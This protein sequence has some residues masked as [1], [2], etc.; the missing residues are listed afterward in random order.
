MGVD[1]SLDDV[2]RDKEFVLCRYKHVEVF[3]NLASAHLPDSTRISVF[4]IQV[5]AYDSKDDW[6]VDETTLPRAGDL[7]DEFDLLAKAARK[8][9]TDARA[10]RNA[11]QTRA[12]LIFSSESLVRWRDYCRAHPGSRMLGRLG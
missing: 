2:T 12:L 8:Q 7:A 9:E 11:L 6:P 10:V 3:L 4:D 1:F 5:S